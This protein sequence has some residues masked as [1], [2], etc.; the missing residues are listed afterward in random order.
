MLP[1]V[2]YF[3]ISTLVITVL[4]AVSCTKVIENDLESKTSEILNNKASNSSITANGREIIIND[5]ASRLTPKDIDNVVSIK[6]VS[7]ALLLQDVSNNLNDASVANLADK[8]KAELSINGY[9]WV[10]VSNKNDE[11]TLSGKASSEEEVNR[12]EDIVTKINGIGILKN[13]IQFIQR[14]QEL[15]QSAL[16][17]LNASWVDLNFNNSDVTISGETI[18]ET[19]SYRIESKIKEINGIGKVTNH[20]KIIERLDNSRCQSKLNNLLSSETILFETNSSKVDNRSKN[21]LKQ[22]SI[23]T[24]QCP[25]ETITIIG[26]TDSSGN[27]ESN[28]NLSQQR[29]GAVLNYL[30]S[31]GV[32]TS[33]LIAQGLGS[34]K[35]IA[36]NATEEGKK[37]NRRIE[38][39]LN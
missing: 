19:I 8:V 24:R 25:G 34:K 9:S 33:R 20:I 13:N 18:D 23:T 39:K 4:A 38:F 2:K 30:N 1:V 28:I 14:Y 37:Q 15:A 16:K 27:E 6:G 21:L 26:H 36:S 11:I 35:P 17:S 5:P 22:L 7:N 10:K 32:A 29:A 3:L 12:I 31:Q